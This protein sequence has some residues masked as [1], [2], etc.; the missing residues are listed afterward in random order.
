MDR[1]RLD[2]GRIREL[3]DRCERQAE[4]RD[5]R[6]PSTP[7]DFDA[8]LEVRGISRRDFLTWTSLATASMMLP[9]I[10]EPMVARAARDLSRLP[11]VWLHFA[12]CTGCTESFLRTAEPTVDSLI[13]DS[14]SLEYHETLMAAAGYQA[15]E[16][17]TRA[18]ADFPGT[19]ICVIEGALPTG[20]GG[21]YLTLGPEGK[22][23]L[24]RAAEVTAQA[25]ATLCIGSCAS[26][27]NVQ[28]AAPNPTDA[29]GV[30]DA[31]GIRTVN[32]AGCPPSPHNF[33]VTLLEYVTTGQWPA[34]DSRGRPHGL[35]RRPVHAQCERKSHYAKEQFVLAWGDEGARQGWCLYKMG[36]KGTITHGNCSEIGFNDGL[37]WPV[38]AG[39]GCIGCTEPRFWDDMAPLEQPLVDDRGQPVEA[40]VAEALGMKGW[41]RKR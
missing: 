13:L 23:G 40:A 22:T 17:L 32:I 36:C 18:M 6:W 26:F 14:L 20:L 5:T 9:K 4:Q 21:R 27:G 34:L 25:A 37:S 33:V 10:F 41:E 1:D 7:V 12:E 28:A 35:Y 11:I 38:R 24:E 30:R 19:Y 2:E 39:H 15:E 31:L 8:A 3:M 29:R 16:N